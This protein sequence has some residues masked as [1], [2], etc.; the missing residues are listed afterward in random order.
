MT[1]DHYPI[2]KAI[3]E[4]VSAP[5]EYHYKLKKGTNI[6]E[7]K[8]TRICDDSETLNEYFDRSITLKKLPL[9]PKV[10]ETSDKFNKSKLYDGN[11]L[12]LIILNSIYII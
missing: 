3:V 8:F 4:D 6:I 7:E 2:Y 9:L 10:Y 1:V 11:I 12:Q 5:V